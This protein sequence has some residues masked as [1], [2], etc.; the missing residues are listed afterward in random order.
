MN[1]ERIIP[2]MKQISELSLGDFR[3]HPVWVGVHNLDSDQPWYSLSNE[4]TYRPWAGDYPVASE[5]TFVL[6]SASYE[7]RDGSRYSGFIRVVSCNWDVPRP[8][9]M[10]NGHIVQYPAPS[11]RHG[12][13]PLTVIGFQRPCI[14]VGEKRFGIWYAR[15]GI[16]EDRRREFYTTIG[17]SPEDVFPLRFDVDAALATGLRSGQLEGFYQATGNEAPFFVR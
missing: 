15:K 12:G 3:R 17:K 8:A 11:S 4:D 7:L 1:S 10:R 6:A 14:F 13:S 16:S 9:R 2:E 5:M